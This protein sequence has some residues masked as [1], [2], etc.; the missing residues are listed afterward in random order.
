M[1][2]I[3]RRVSTELTPSNAPGEGQLDADI[4]RARGCAIQQRRAC[5]QPPR[6]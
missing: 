6:A 4:E 2:A 5:A 1:D 3:L